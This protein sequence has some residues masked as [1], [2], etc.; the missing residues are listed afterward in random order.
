[1]IDLMMHSSRFRGAALIL[2][3]KRNF[4]DSWHYS[5]LI[6][7][8][9]VMHYFLSRNAVLKSLEHPS[10]YNMQNDELYELDDVSFQFLQRCSTEEGCEGRDREFVDYCLKEGILS[11]Q[12]VVLKRPALIKA[13]EPSLRYLELQVTTNCNL[14]CMHCYIGDDQR[15]RA[16]GEGAEELSAGMIRA[17]LQEFEEMQG[18]RVLISGGEPLLHTHFK[19]INSILPEF[20]LRKVLITN[21][22]LLTADV[23]SGLNVQEIQVSID[24]LEQA[25]DSL[26]GK[27]TFRSAI[28]GIRGA[29]RAGFQVS[30]STMV[31]RGNLK[32]FDNMEKLFREIGISDWTVDVPCIT[33]RLKQHPEF[34]ISP[35]VGGKYLRYGFG[36]GLHTG[37]SGF[38]CGTHLMAVTA[39]GKTAKCTF[40]AENAVGRIKDG[41][42][43]SWQRLE[44]VRLDT[45]SCDCAYLSE[46][47]GGCRYRA[48]LLGDI[49]GK[50]FYKCHSYDMLG[51]KG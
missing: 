35:E 28:N 51:G 22:V 18:L 32:D 29:L 34:Q 10:V 13:P 33:G 50:D 40:F 26:R 44:P 7:Y 39:H 24:G 37:A 45:L 1:M 5:Y 20:F 42:R 47:R 41:L 36:E 27:G 19:E 6:I 8:N 25:H 49:Y 46:C 14:R 4:T 17:I 31:H 30:V 2:Y 23:L 3:H 11:L 38:A 9:T 12:R 48:L 21:G 43:E 15:V 16:N